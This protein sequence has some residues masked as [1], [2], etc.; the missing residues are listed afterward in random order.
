[1]PW[2]REKYL[3][4]NKFCSHVRSSWTSPRI[5]HADS[6]TS[7]KLNSHKISNK[8]QLQ[9]DWIN[10]FPLCSTNTPNTSL[11]YEIQNTIKVLNITVKTLKYH[12]AFKA[13]NFNFEIQVISVSQGFISDPN[14]TLEDRKKMC[15]SDTD[16]SVCKINF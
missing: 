8:K 3:I 11:K 12:E 4:L 9:S 2:F 5:S 10:K 1:M 14:F 7:F 15:M 16:I 6:D 13:L